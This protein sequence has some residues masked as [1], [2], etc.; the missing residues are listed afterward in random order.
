MVTQAM[1]LSFLVVGSNIMT[2]LNPKMKSTMN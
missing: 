1:S 2:I